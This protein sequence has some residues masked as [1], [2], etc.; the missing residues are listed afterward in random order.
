MKVFTLA[1]S[2]AVWAGGVAAQERAHETGGSLLAK[3]RTAQAGMSTGAGDMRD[4][5][6][7]GT[8]VG[9]LLAAADAAASAGTREQAC[10]PGNVSREQLVKA[11]TDYLAQT[12]EAREARAIESVRKAYA[13][14]FAC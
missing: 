11:V 9:Y 1:V 8:C 14:A 6:D 12:P 4:A 3:C 5:V 2:A 7:A 10:I 13:A